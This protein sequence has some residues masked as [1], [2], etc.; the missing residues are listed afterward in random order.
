MPNE[1]VDR[2]KLCEDDLEVRKSATVNVIMQTCEE[3]PTDKLPNHF[4]DW[5]KLEVDVAW[6]LKVKGT[7]NSLCRKERTISRLEGQPK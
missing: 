7:L 2:V 6:I 4:S 3:R 1:C 5:T